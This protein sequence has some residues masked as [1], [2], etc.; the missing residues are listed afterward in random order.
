[1]TPVS[2]CRFPLSTVQ[3][4]GVTRGLERVRSLRYIRAFS[5]LGYMKPDDF[6]LCC[7][8]RHMSQHLRSFPLR[9]D[10]GAPAATTKSPT[11][12]H[13]VRP[14]HSLS[15]KPHLDTSPFLCLYHLITYTRP[16]ST[17]LSPRHPSLAGS[18]TRQPEA[19]RK[20]LPNAFVRNVAL[21]PFM[22]IASAATMTLDVDGPR[23][24]NGIRYLVVAVPLTDLQLLSLIA[25][26]LSPTL[27]VA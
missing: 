15:L 4:D 2:L 3:C 26:N 9:Q 16:L 20:M 14:L 19:A 6:T 11:R 1:M 24:K 21:L 7:N 13:I 8:V 27:L 18:T 17:P 23:C 5:T 22:L 12:T 10:G 25:T